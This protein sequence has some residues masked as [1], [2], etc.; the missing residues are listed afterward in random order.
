MRPGF[1]IDVQIAILFAVVQTGAEQLDA[2]SVAKVTVYGLGNQ[3]NRGRGD[4][5]LA[6]RVV[7]TLSQVA[8][9]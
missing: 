8:D 2:C 5:H 7:G 6:V 4:A 3:T 1:D 9:A